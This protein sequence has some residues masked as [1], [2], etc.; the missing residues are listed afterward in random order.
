MKLAKPA[1]NT[2]Q[3]RAARLLLTVVLTLVVVMGLA[4]QV[5]AG[6]DNATDPTVDSEVIAAGSTGTATG[7]AQT[8]P[9]IAVEKPDYVAVLSDP[10]P[11]VE[12]AVSSNGILVYPT[13]PLLEG[14]LVSLQIAPQIPAEV[15][16]ENVEVQVLIDGLEMGVIPVT[17]N[18]L[19]QHPTARFEWFWDTSGLSGEH[20]LEI[21]IDPADSIQRGDSNLEDNSIALVIEIAA[22]DPDAP[23]P[24][25]RGWLTDSSECCLLHFISD[26]ISESEIDLLKTA[27]DRAFSRAASALQIELQGPYDVYFSESV[28]GQG[29][30]SSDS[31]L[32][33]HTQRNYA[34][35]NLAQLLAHEAVHILDQ[36]YVPSRMDFLAEGVAVWAAG[37]HYKSEDLE[38]RA[39]MLLK[40]ELMRPL[41]QLIDS[42]Y[43]TQHEI[44][45]L[46]AAAFVQYLID[47]YGWERVR[48]FYRDVNATVADSESIA[49][50][51]NL[52]YHFGKTL[53]GLETQW[54][55]YLSTL[56]YSK[57]TID[58]LLTSIR[59]YELVR[60]YQQQYEPGKYFLSG[61]L[62][63]PARA[64]ELG[65]TADFV[66]RPDDTV[67]LVVENLLVSAS[68]YLHSSRF[69]LANGTLDTVQRILDSGGKYRDPLAVNYLNLVRATQDEGYEPVEITI[70][71]RFAVVEGVDRLSASVEG[72]K[73]EASERNWT[74]VN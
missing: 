12:L 13:G 71:G 21:V 44:G 31:M 54:H 49:I 2:Q 53:A 11:V 50:D 25:E 22:L 18:D 67:N 4:C 43:P 69:T 7:N 52:R 35:G 61:W 47:I 68:R 55:T 70:S 62:P 34:A 66:R 33:T 65:V 63:N 23:E 10:E 5:A 40:A 60:D 15:A 17:A 39:S 36:Q 59:Y 32:V 3:S 51:G 38:R 1:T 9:S 74:L 45:Y 57:Q 30:Y 58:D 8:T 14:D 24:Y 19:A 16:A 37:G 48:S 72:L 27:V 73:F 20:V 26:S 41:D 64:E 42:F 29:A 56:R 46:Q 6:G 28:W